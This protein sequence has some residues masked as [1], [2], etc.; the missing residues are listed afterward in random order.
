M[1]PFYQIPGILV[2][3]FT[4][5]I[6]EENPISDPPHLKWIGLI[7]STILMIF[8]LLVIVFVVFE[9]SMDWIGYPIQFADSPVVDFDEDLQNLPQGLN[10]EELLSQF[11]LLSP[12]PDSSLPNGEVTILCTWDANYHFPLWNMQLKV[13]NM[14]IPWELQFG[15]NTWLARL[16]LEPGF[17]R[18]QTPG[19]DASFFVE[20]SGLTPPPNWKSFAMHKDIGNPNRCHECHHWIDN[21]D[22]IVRTGHALTIGSWKGNE[23]CLV[24]H[25]NE[26]FEKKHL[27]IAAPETDCRSCHILHGA[28]VHGAAASGKLL[29]YP[30]N[31][32]QPKLKTE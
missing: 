6:S 15:K 28:A 21:S 24:C 8:F 25:Q 23:S 19:F 14:A 9:S 3:H 26:S 31:D 16:Q 10:T 12:L 17:H 1:S 5:F 11:Y 27:Q 4:S 13:D 20:G 32:F 18:L 29:K 30:K 7:V 2:G 22:D